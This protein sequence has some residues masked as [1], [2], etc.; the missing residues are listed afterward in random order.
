MLKTLVAQPQIP[1]K[2]RVTCDKGPLPPERK[3]RTE[4]DAE[5]KPRRNNQKVFGLHLSEMVIKG[6]KRA[7]NP[8]AFAPR[9][10]GA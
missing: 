2:L 5:A 3:H 9:L 1:F 4:G 8:F 7:D 10:A 6:M